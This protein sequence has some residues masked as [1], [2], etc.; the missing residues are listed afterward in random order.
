V[1]TPSDDTWA[2]VAHDSRCTARAAAPPISTV[3]AT[4]LAMAVPMATAM[5][6][7]AEAAPSTLTASVAAMLASTRVIR[8]MAS[9]RVSG[10]TT[11]TFSA[12]ATAGGYNM[13]KGSSVLRAGCCIPRV[14][15]G[16]DRRWPSRGQQPRRP[17][18]GLSRKG[19]RPQR[20]QLG[21]PCWRLPRHQGRRPRHQHPRHDRDRR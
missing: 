1:W 8:A 14:G 4:L 2:S 16:D 10:A 5:D 18:R 9:S 3:V 7:T 13:G 19:G 17:G 21:S 12:V 15:T 6:E 11:T 20:L